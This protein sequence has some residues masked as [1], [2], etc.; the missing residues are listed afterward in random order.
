[1]M[2]LAYIGLG[3]NLG[4][5]EK[6]IKEAA[7]LIGKLGGVELRRKSSIYVTEPVGV[8]FQ[9]W[10]CNA[11]IEV[12]T[13]LTPWELLSALE[14]IEKEM[15]RSSKGDG[16]PRTIDL[17]ILLFGNIR[18]ESDRL[19]VPHPRLME[20]RFAIEPLVELNGGL[21]CPGE[22]GTLSDWLGELRGGE[23]EL[24]KGSSHEW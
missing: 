21:V 22:R 9:P 13:S 24:R 20:R 10:Y 12:A 15:G 3:S 23:V 19:T 8:S 18:V 17:D 2:E 7:A 14:G 5:R 4:E 11:V 6:N 1:M 16:A